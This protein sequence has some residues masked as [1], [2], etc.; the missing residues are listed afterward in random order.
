MRNLLDNLHTNFKSFVWNQRGTKLTVRTCLHVH[1]LRG[2]LN[3]YPLKN[4]QP[5]VA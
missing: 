1:R 5:A 4:K 2:L 3:G